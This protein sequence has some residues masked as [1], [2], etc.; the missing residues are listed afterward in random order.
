MK[1]DVLTQ[2]SKLKFDNNLIDQQS[3]NMWLI[4]FSEQ[5]INIIDV[6]TQPFLQR[7]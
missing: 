3:L 6:T 2:N 1:N 7:N 4:T 5:L